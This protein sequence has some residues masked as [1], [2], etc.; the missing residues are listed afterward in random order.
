MN[1]DELTDVLNAAPPAA[2][3]TACP[4]LQPTGVRRE[5][6]T[7]ADID[8]APERR[9]ARPPP[10]RRS[11]RGAVKRRAAVLVVALAAIVVLVYGLVTYLRTK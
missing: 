9:S 4:S 7:P 6:W 11:P 8:A 10:V 3:H 1:T 5:R 2:D